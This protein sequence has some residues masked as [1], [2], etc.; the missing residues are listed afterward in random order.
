MAYA[1]I[2]NEMPL[3]GFSF[4]PVY[5]TD[6][7]SNL[8]PQSIGRDAIF[9]AV[10]V[11]LSFAVNLIVWLYSLFVIIRYYSKNRSVSR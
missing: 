2:V 6:K 9:V 3:T 8:G 4:D 5:D 7:S 10:I 11:V 1:L